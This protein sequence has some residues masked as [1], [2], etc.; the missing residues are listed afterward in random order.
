MKD[1]VDLIDSNNKEYPSEV[2]EEGFGYFSQEQIDPEAVE[3]ELSY[4]DD[5]LN[6]KKEILQKLLGHNFYDY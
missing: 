1:L 4:W 2:L 3:G 5:P 6:E